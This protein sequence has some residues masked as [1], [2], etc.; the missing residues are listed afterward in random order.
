MVASNY[1][2]S[3]CPEHHS[4]NRHVQHICNQY[5]CDVLLGAHALN[6]KNFILGRENWY[7]FYNFWLFVVDIVFVLP[8]LPAS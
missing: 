1:G 7:P 8:Y 6:Y 3:K 2:I 5:I 4:T